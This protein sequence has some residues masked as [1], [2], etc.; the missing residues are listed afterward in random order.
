M[1]DYYCLQM[2]EPADTSFAGFSKDYFGTLKDRT[3]FAINPDPIFKWVLD[4]IFA[5]G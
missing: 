4:D 1:S 2:D 3:N 5:D